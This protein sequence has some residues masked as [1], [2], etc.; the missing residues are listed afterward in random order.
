MAKLG[1]TTLL[2]NSKYR[3]NPNGTPTSN[4]I[5]RFKQKVENVV[6]I[7][8]LQCV[9]ENGVYN[10]ATNN[11]TF[12]FTQNVSTTPTITVITIPTN[13]YDD[14]TLMFQIA[15]LLNDACILTNS[16]GVKSLFFADITSQGYFN[17]WCDTSND[18]SLTFDTVDSPNT[19]LLLGFPGSGPYK[20]IFGSLNGP[21]YIA[22]P[23]NP[24]KL[25][26][27]DSILIQSDRLG[28]EI[29]SNQGFSAFFSIPNGNWLKAS[30]TITYDN[31]RPPVLDVKMATPRDIEWVDIRVIDNDGN[32]LDLA[33]NDCH[34]V[35][36]FYTEEAARK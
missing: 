4:F 22:R 7:N 8:L 5:Y 26:N 1:R 10:I 16:T 33:G 9:I 31:V 35:V 12:T 27:Y 29:A 2:I 21:F 18:W 15:A 6:H 14:E 24:M 36:E 11:Q 34:F 32:E 30:T 25:S 20:P 13:Y 23:A 17:L 3:V 19:G 28:N